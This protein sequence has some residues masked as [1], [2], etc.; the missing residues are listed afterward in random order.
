MTGLADFHLHIG[1]E[2]S[3]DAQPR[4]ENFEDERIAELDQLNAPA[5]ADTK[6]FEALHLLVVGRDCADDGADARREQIQPDESRL[7]V[8]SGCHNVV[9][10]NCPT[11]KSTQAH[12]QVDIKVGRA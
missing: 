5:E 6:R 3:G 1:R 12:R 8:I 10:L 11:S 7:G 4:A 9:K 2:R